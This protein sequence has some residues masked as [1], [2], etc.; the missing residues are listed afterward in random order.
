M[1]EPAQA[2]ELQRENRKLKRQIATLEQLI[3]RSS[4]NQMAHT[5][6]STLLK[7][8]KSRQENYMN[9][10]MQNCPDILIL[11]DQ[12]RRFVNCT[13]AFLK[14]ADILSLGLINTKTFDE[15]FAAFLPDEALT[16]LL[17]HFDNAAAGRTTCEFEAEL[18]VGSSQQPRHYIVSFTPMLDN[19]GT[20]EGW[21]VQMHDVSDLLRAKALAEAANNAKSDFLTTVSHEIRTPMNAI[22]GV[23]DMMKKLNPTGKMAEHLD[24]IQA[25]SQTLLNL[26]NDILD[27]SKIEAQRLDIINDFFSLT[28]LLN[29]LKT[30]FDNLFSESIVA[31]ECQFDPD[32]PRVVYGDEKRIR[33]VLTN[34]LTNALKYTR[35]GRVV[36]RASRDAD[37]VFVFDIEDTGIGIKQED[38]PRLFTAFE[39]LDKVKNKNVVGTGLGLA[40]TRQLCHLMLGDVSLTSTYGSGSCFTIKLPLTVGREEDLPTSEIEDC[41]FT[42]PQ[43]TVLVVDDIDI[44]VVVTASVLENYGI[45]ADEAYSGAEAIEKAAQKR[46][47]LIFMD[48]MMPEM[49]GIEATQR[50]RALGGDKG[51]TPIVA[52][53][54]NAVSGAQEMFLANGLDGFLSKPIVASELGQ[55][56]LK[57]LPKDKIHIET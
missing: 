22:I 39:Q 8:E 46:Y 54:A 41:T 18:T 49:D 24:N 53:T 43:A 12:D 20:P 14:K 36:L 26:I 19:D 9:L 13:D 31:F 50:I 6:L 37:G 27:F 35:E 48:H 21:L 11:L 45:T 15:V 44:N 51:N 4:Q 55:C 52:L 57:H 2:I 42:A 32:L 29:S 1:D 16:S 34:L 30:M 23:S 47:D 33:Q 56:L 38:V 3:E 5:K 17:Q 40:I 28:A 10:L 7:Q 25:S